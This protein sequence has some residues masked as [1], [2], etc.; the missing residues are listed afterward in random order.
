MDWKAPKNSR[1]SLN[2]VAPLEHINCFRR[3]SLIKMAAIAGMEEVVIPMSIQ[4]AYTSN[5][6]GEGE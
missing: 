3:K 2:P 4:Y 1:N 5:W 6:Y